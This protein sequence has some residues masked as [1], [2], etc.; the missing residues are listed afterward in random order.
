MLR[1]AYFILDTSASLT[2]SYVELLS[3][4]FRFRF[5]MQV[6]TSSW[7]LNGEPRQATSLPKLSAK[8]KI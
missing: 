8:S 4:S 3:T 7:L 6:L 1:V 2:V 5:Y